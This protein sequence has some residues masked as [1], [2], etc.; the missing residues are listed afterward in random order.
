M[1]AVQPDQINQ[2]NEVKNLKYLE[3]V[4]AAAIK[5]V[6]CV[7]SLYGY[8]KDNSGPLKPGVESVEGTV[9]TVVAPVVDKFHNVPLELLAFV[10]RK[11][12][13][14]IHGLERHVPERVKEVYASAQKA[15]ELVRSV[16]GEVQKAGVVGTAAG[17]VRGVYGKYQPAAKEMYVKYEPVAEQYAVTAW[18]SLNQ[19]PLFPQLAQIVIP[20]AACLTEK[21]N[22]AVGYGAERG[23]AVSA[24]LPIVPTEKI[25]KVFG[26]VDHAP[27]E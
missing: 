17:I 21:Y 12:E 27:A 5:A 1:A 9:K 7:S 14:S 25:A 6:M 4:H 13:D 23:Y 2:E 20:T 11:V 10:D 16:A 8:A 22:Q 26:D 3:F 18:R 15:P 19:V 24:Y